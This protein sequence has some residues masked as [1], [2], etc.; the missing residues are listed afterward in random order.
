M[1]QY[2]KFGEPSQHWY[3]PDGTA[4]H[5]VDLRVARKEILF[6]SCTSVEK[7]IF[8]NPGLDRWKQNELVAACLENPRQPHESP[9]DYATRVYELS[10][11]KSVT[12]SDFGNEI[13][14]AIDK[15]P[16]TPKAKLIPWI[17][18][19]RPWYEANVAEDIGK[20]LTYIDPEIGV[21]G[22]TDRV[23]MHKLY[24]RSI[25]DWKTQGIKPD[26]KGRRA[27]LYYP[28]WL[29]QLAFYASCDAKESGI[30][31]DFP[32]CISLVIDSNEVSDPYMKVWDKQDVAAAY[33]AF[34]VGVWMW[35]DKRDYWPVGKWDLVPTVRM[36]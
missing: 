16:E 8:T 4:R 32:T 7:D 21:A 25:C 18:R 28:S 13:H 27:P 22:R 26:K 19:F 1:G 2:I 23:I 9:E 5:N 3:L 35:C 14:D 34:V 17:D 36:P 24:G 29:R 12:A 30:W 6:P 15:Y 31:P 33:K 11:M 10:L 20:E